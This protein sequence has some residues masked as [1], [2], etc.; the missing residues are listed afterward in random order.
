L[1]EAAAPAS[2]SG[3]T[4][5][6]LVAGVAVGVGLVCILAAAVVAWRLGSRRS[7]AA[8]AGAGSG[9]CQ[10]GLMMGAE[11]G[12]TPAAAFAALAAAGAGTSGVYRPG[13][14]TLAI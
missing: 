3:T 10:Q 8:A 6:G 2:S 12:V 11:A 4:S 7:K 13:A 5:V 14:A 9:A 1:P